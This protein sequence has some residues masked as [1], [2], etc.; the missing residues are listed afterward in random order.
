VWRKEDVNNIVSQT[1]DS[2]DDQTQQGVEGILQ[3]GDYLLQ[4]G[5]ILPDAF[6]T[7]ETHGTLN[8][9]KSNVIVNPTWYTGSHIAN[10]AAIGPG[11]MLDTNQ[12]FVI[13]PDMF[14]NG[15]SSSPSNTPP[16]NDR[17]RFPLVTIYDNVFAQKRLC[18]EV[19]G[20][21]K[22]KSVVGFSMGAQQAF[23]WAAGFPETVESMVAICGTGKTS[24]HDWLH[25]EGAKSA[26]MADEA[27]AN[28]DYREPPTVGIRA[29]HAVSAG[30]VASQAYFRKG[31][32]KNFLGMPAE[33]VSGFIDNLVQAFQANDANDLLGALATWQ[34]ADVTNY[35]RFEG[36][37]DKAYGS[38]QCRAMVMPCRTDLYFPPEDN[39]AEVARMPNAELRVI[40]SDFGHLAGLPGVSE[41]TDQ[42]VAQGVA[43]ILNA[44]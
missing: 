5:Q 30:W 41:E 32:Y 3:L 16:P 27:W 36:D 11:R 39:E 4:S 17:A 33:T 13:V 44:G 28:G 18:E 15:Y 38:I 31:M 42:F 34:H 40:E 22:I 35:P 9:D 21:E 26:L 1:S 43:D 14:C 37:L 12:Y 19:F 23:H 2:M 25:L 24:P 6:L 7:Y 8:E 10:R 20:I 29:F